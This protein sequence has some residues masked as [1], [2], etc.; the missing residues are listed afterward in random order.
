MYPGLVPLIYEIFTIYFTS[1]MGFLWLFWMAKKQAG[2]KN[3]FVK[4]WAYGKYG[5]PF[6]GAWP[7]T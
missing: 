5:G 2:P 4:K 7:R 6:G 3:I 1:F